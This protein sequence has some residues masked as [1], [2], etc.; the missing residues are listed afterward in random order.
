M[1]L[2]STARSEFS[3]FLLFQDPDQ[4]ATYR[5]ALSFEGYDCYVFIDYEIF[6]DRVKEKAPDLVVFEMDALMGTLSEFVQSILEISPEVHF[7][8][9]VEP[10]AAEALIPYRDYNFIGLFTGGPEAKTRLLWQVDAHFSEMTLNRKLSAAESAV[11]QARAQLERS[12]EQIEEA[13]SLALKA[14][15]RVPA[16]TNTWS[17]SDSEQV[18]RKAHSREEMMT[19]FLERVIQVAV[20]PNKATSSVGLFFKY[21]STLFNLVA[22]QSQGLSL[23]KLKGVGVKLTPVEAEI[24]S[25]LARKFQ[26][27]MP[28]QELLQQ[29]F[30]VADYYLRPLWS[31]RGLE[32]VMVF[33]PANDFDQKALDNEWSVFSSQFLLIDLKS[34]YDELNVIDPVTEA[35][36]REFYL[37]TLEMEVSRARRLQKPVSVIKLTLDQWADVKLKSGELVRESILKSLVAI[38]KKTGRTNDF[39]CLTKQGELSLILPHSARQGAAVR[40]ER[41]RR[42]VEAQSFQYAEGPLTISCGVS[43]YPSFC[44][45]A[46]ELDHTAGQAMAYIQARGGNKL[47]LYKPLDKFKPD[48]E[49]PPI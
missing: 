13:R 44:S 37:K 26:A 36:T 28:L 42:I 17:V 30:V 41:L 49:V 16:P 19:R 46:V 4:A 1:K 10:A 23:E 45:S 43:E 35:H 38:I 2:S 5:E 8:P 27:P 33:W 32:G 18:Y 12:S 34:K 25:D 6:L 48:F 39:V 14:A 31:V 7:L 3:V 9:T 29:G 11:E 47:C 15:E 24:F 40:A 20:P 22:T 21:I